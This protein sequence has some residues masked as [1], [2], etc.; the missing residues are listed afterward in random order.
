M[1]GEDREMSSAGG[2]AASAAGGS[3]P[4]STASS[5]LNGMLEEAQSRILRI[6]AEAVA[7]VAAVA[8]A[9]AGGAGAEAAG[10]AA[11]SAAPA[12]SSSSLESLLELIK[13]EYDRLPASTR[14]DGLD[15]DTLQKVMRYLDVLKDANAGGRLDIGLLQRVSTELFGIEAPYPALTKLKLMEA[16]ILLS[17]DAIAGAQFVCKE[18]FAAGTKAGD[19]MGELFGS[20]E[21]ATEDMGFAKTFLPSKKIVLNPAGTTDQGGRQFVG[22]TLVRFPAEGATVRLTEEECALFGMPESAVKAE[23]NGDT[24]TMTWTHPSLKE[25]PFVATRTW[26][27]KHASSSE[28]E[29][30]FLGNNVIHEMLAGDTEPSRLARILLFGKDGLFGDTG[31]VAWM[32]KYISEE[33]IDRAKHAMMTH[34]M[35]MLMLLILTKCTAIV[36]QVSVVEKM[37]ERL[38]K[39]SATA[40]ESLQESLRD[41]AASNVSPTAVYFPGTPTCRSE[42]ESARAV[43]EKKRNEDILKCRMF[44]DMVEHNRGVVASLERFC[45]N[46]RSF[47]VSGVAYKGGETFPGFCGAVRAF[48]PPVVAIEDILAMTMEDARK[49]CIVHKYKLFVMKSNPTTI[50]QTFTGL[51]DKSIKQTDSVCDFLKP[52]GGTFATALQ[53]IHQSRGLLVMRKRTRRSLRQVQRGGGREEVLKI[54][55]EFGGSLVWKGELPFDTESFYTWVD[56]YLSFVA[57]SSNPAALWLLYEHYYTVYGQNPVNTTIEWTLYEFGHIYATVVHGY[58]EFSVRAF[59]EAQIDQQWVDVDAALV[60]ANADAAAAAAAEESY[61]S[62][63]GEVTSGHGMPKGGGGGSPFSSPAGT[64]TAQSPQAPLSIGTTPSGTPRGTPRGGGGGPASTNLYGFEMQSPISYVDP[65]TEQEIYLQQLAMVHTTRVRNLARGLGYRVIPIKN[66][67]HCFYNALGAGLARLSPAFLD[68]HRDTRSLRNSMRYNSNGAFVVPSDGQFGGPDMLTEEAVSGFCVSMLSY[69]TATN[70][71]DERVP[72]RFAESCTSGNT[73]YLLHDGVGHVDLLVGPGQPPHP[74]DTVWQPSGGAAAAAA[75]SASIKPSLLRRLFANKGEA[76]SGSVSSAAGVH[77]TPPHGAAR[78]AG[79]S[80]LSR[81]AAAD[82]GSLSR[83]TPT[84]IPAPPQL[85]RESNKTARGLMGQS[86]TVNPGVVAYRADG[87]D[88]SAANAVE[89]MAAHAS[90]L[91]PAAAGGGSS[92]SS[93]SSSSAAAPPGPLSRSLSGSSTGSAGKRSASAL[94]TS[95]T[96]GNNGEDSASAASPQQYVAKKKPSSTPPGG[97]SDGRKNRRTRRIRRNRNNRSQKH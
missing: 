76:G 54:I 3:S 78:G 55:G 71:F 47:T 74:D 21:G 52:I 41:F 42:E 95:A 86:A 93:S 61:L 45:R 79:R 43:V 63:G 13:L 29:N 58:S 69:N 35:V 9:A 56:P 67:G 91:P 1:R 77:V 30:M 40:P 97:N 84:K 49:H 37:I 59:L 39:H 10:A 34:D 15:W 7:A 83:S 18:S 20:I 72:R 31:L 88:V 5:V 14:Y 62:E 12:R 16:H 92:S 60:A 89:S 50:Q 19:R 23:N 22:E 51:L 82:S 36:P 2:G 27:G 64:F 11:S 6:E 85:I 24:C 32:L 90:L 44:V 38:K 81:P 70:T 94:G 96:N 65:F 26:A 28:R 87:I 4:A 73:V 66:D 46:H 25:G 75:A 68:R 80:A 53:R 8:V 33:G 57:N 48:S 17:M